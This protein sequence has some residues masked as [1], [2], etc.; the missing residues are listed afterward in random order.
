MDNC[1]TTTCVALHT[2]LC[3]SSRRS[4]CVLQ[5]RAEE[6]SETQHL[7]K[8]KFSGHGLDK[9][10]LRKLFEGGLRPSVSC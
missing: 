10:V 2:S 3:F 4:F 1:Y 9:K 8:L 5:I 6:V 7:Y